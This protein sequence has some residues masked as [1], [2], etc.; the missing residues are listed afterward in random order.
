M[1]LSHAK[2]LPTPSATSP[3]RR[4]SWLLSQ[5]T[6]NPSKAFFSRHLRGVIRAG[7]RYDSVNVCILERAH[8]G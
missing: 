4:F 1:V 2:E 6:S 7:L 5:Q 8:P 3:Q